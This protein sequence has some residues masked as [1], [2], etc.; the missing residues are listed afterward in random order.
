VAY[1]RGQED[2]NNGS[3]DL[4]LSVYGYLPGQTASDQLT[5][6]IDSLPFA[7]A[8]NDTIICTYNQY[9]L[10]GAAGNYSSVLWGTTGDGTFNDATLLNAT[11]IPGTADTA[12]GFVELFLTAYSLACEDSSIST[13][14]LWFDPCFGI[15]EYDPASVRIRIFP[16]PNS[17]VFDLEVANIESKQLEIR[18]LNTKGQIIFNQLLTNFTGRFSKQFDMNLLEKGVYYI[19][20]RVDGYSS[21]GKL[22]IR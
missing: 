1:L 21:T 20:I 13:M 14:T 11:Y 2:I 18:M 3:V 5:L 6:Y 16:N 7:D 4:T 15:D 9:T 12:S 8:G 19:R 17:G 10:H 22:I